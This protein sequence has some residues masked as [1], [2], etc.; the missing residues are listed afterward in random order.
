MKPIIFIALSLICSF[1]SA[2]TRPTGIPTQYSTGWFRHGFQ[3]SDSGTIIASRS[4]SGWLPTFTGTVVFHTDRRPYFY[5]K[6]ELQWYKFLTAADTTSLS[7]RINLKLNISDTASMLSP[8]LR[9]IDTTAKWVTN[10]RRVPGTLNVEMQK[11]GIWTTAYTD[12]I[13]TGGGGGTVTSVGLSMPSAFS[14]SGSPVTTSGTI[15]VSGAGTTL[16]YIRGNGTLATLDTTAIPSFSVKVRSLFSGTSPIQYSNGAISILNATTVQKGAASFNASHF[17]VSSGAVS[18]SNVVTAGSCTNCDISFTADGRAASYSNGT[19]GSPGGSNTQ[20]Q[21][22]DAGAF[23]GNSG[24]TYNKTTNTANLDTGALRRLQI[25]VSGNFASDTLVAFGDS[26]TVGVGAT[27]V[28]F[29]YARLLAAHLQLLIKNFG[30][31]GSTLMKRSPIDPYGAVNMVDRIGDIPTKTARHKYLLFAYGLNDVGYNSANYTPTNF[32]IDYRTV[33]DA[34]L[35]KGW[36][37]TDIILITPWYISTDGYASYASTTGTPQ[38]NA[39]RHLQFVDTVLAL[40]SQYGT[41]VF[42]IYRSQ[43]VSGGVGFVSNDNIH[44]ANTGHA[45]I[46]GQIS[47]YVGYTVLKNNQANATNGVT[48][49]QQLRLTAPDSALDN[50]YGRILELDTLGMVRVLKTNA[51]VRNNP[52]AVPDAQQIYIDGKIIT[53]PNNSLATITDVERIISIGG[54]KGHFLRANGSLPGG[55]VGSAVE[56]G[57]VG[58]TGYVGAYDRTGSS[59]LNLSINALGGNVLVGTLTDGGERLQVNGSVA[60]DLGSDATGDVFY[61]N[62]G[63]SFTRLG[64]GSSGDVLTVNTGLPVW[65]APAAATTLYNG[66]G[67][68]SS[69]RTVT[70]G[71]NNLTFDASSSGDLKFTLGSDATGDLYYAASGGALTRRAIGS[72]GDVL[73]VSGGLPVWQAPDY[74]SGT[75]TP[76]LTNSTNVT[77]STAYQCQY[78]RVGNVVHVSGKVD[79]D[80]T[81]ATTLTVLE[82]SL[83]IASAVPNDF[84]LAGTGSGNALDLN[85][86]IKA[87]T[88]NDTAEINFTPTTTVSNQSW[89]FTF[90]YLIDNS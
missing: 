41:N 4:I 89:F 21:F 86:L 16:Q 33:L 66:N 43:S 34:A 20:I 88:T 68:I 39:T 84:E 26:Y 72:S 17:S 62:S 77:A 18:L 56:I 60:L 7:N 79:I 37:A 47:S 42:D 87:N 19:A 70:L 45:F 10:M 9:K 44:P 31:S 64:I 22:N 85:G 63:G 57:L 59:P 69:A 2:Q 3:Q 32:S 5:D 46:A 65:S 76:T 80:P 48:E 73:T 15:S 28:Q 29:S 27:S 78:I 23:G 55:M 14:V 83:P 81:S 6:I 13:G 82:I 11:G 54:V 53:S 50:Y 35:A 8:Y 67:S 36:A 61:R 38:V 1:V 25:G 51:I 24:F 58:S 30:V 71:S 74:A 75:Y 49:L 12:S 52:S 40:A 90:T